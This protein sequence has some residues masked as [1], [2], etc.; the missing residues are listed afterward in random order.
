MSLRKKKF[1]EKHVLKIL[2]WFCDIPLHPRYVSYFKTQLSNLIS[3]LQSIHDL[4]K[5]S[6]EIDD[7]SITRLQSFGDCYDTYFDT[8]SEPQ[9]PTEELPYLGHLIE[10]M[11]QHPHSQIGMTISKMV[12]AKKGKTNKL[13]QYV[14]KGSFGKLHVWFQTR[15]LLLKYSEFESIERDKL[16]GAC[17][18]ETYMKLADLGFCKFVRLIFVCIVYLQMLN[19]LHHKF[20]ASPKKNARMERHNIY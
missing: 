8:L 17:P 13:Q 16:V 1:R 18:I 3:F 20:S 9:E 7:T 14:P 5:S 12:N 6:I 19:N 4:G 2:L 10:Y 11:K 15:K